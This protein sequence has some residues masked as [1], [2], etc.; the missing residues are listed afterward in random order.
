MKFT[1]LALA[2]TATAIRVTNTEEKC[3]SL[4]ETNTFFNGLDTNKNGE[5]SEKEFIHALLVSKDLPDTPGTK[6][7]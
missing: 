1:L 3:Y 4:T 6:E 2:T 7:Y 5:L